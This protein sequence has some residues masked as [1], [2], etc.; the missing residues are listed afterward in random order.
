MVIYIPLFREDY[1]SY[2]TS[3]DLIKKEEKQC[4]IRELF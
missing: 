3:I 4:F 2:N 1:L